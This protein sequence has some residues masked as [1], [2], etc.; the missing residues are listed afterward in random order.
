MR[1][2]DVVFEKVPG[3]FCMLVLAP[4]SILATDCALKRLLLSGKKDCGIDRVRLMRLSF[5]PWLT[6]RLSKKVPFPILNV[7]V[8]IAVGSMCL[9]C[10]NREGLPVLPFELLSA[11]DVSK[12][13]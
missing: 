3:T 7:E 13:E 11:V 1:A 4:D 2:K 5:D 10:W 6:A 9:K 8:D 12:V